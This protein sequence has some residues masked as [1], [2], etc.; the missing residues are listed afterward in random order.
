MTTQIDRIREGVE[1]SDWTTAA[2]TR[3]GTAMYAKPGRGLIVVEFVPETGVVLATTICLDGTT[4]TVGADKTQLERVC[5]ALY[6]LD[7]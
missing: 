6:A 3:P 4:K 5:A 1:F 7:E 2:E